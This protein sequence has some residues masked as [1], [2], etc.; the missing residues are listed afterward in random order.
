MQHSC[1]MPKIFDGFVWKF[2]KLNKKNW[3]KHVCP[4]E[5]NRT[6]PIWDMFSND[7]GKNEYENLSVALHWRSLPMAQRSRVKDVGLLAEN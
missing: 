6:N 3:T 2:Q 4:C 7:L 1:G 5:G